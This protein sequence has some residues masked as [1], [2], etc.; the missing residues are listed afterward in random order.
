MKLFLLRLLTITLLTITLT[1]CNNPGEDEYNKG[2]DALREN[3]YEYAEKMF[4]AALEKDPSI[5]E[6]HISLGFVYLRTD[7]FDKAWDETSLGLEMVK[8]DKKSIVMGGT[9]QDQAVQAYNNL[10]KIVFEK[11]VNARRNGDMDAL[12]RH[13]EHAI[14]LFKQ[15]LELIPDHETTLK[16]L[17]YAERW[18]N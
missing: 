13:K 18:P 17:T 7:K 15:A 8:R 5:V 3:N 2:T 6:A 16:N 10:A 1:G 14:S 12:Q 4:K 9:W 11:A